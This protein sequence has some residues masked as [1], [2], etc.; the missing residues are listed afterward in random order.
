MYHRRQGGWEAGQMKH[1]AMFRGGSALLGLVVSSAA[2]AAG[3]LPALPAA[4][5]GQTA[6]ATPAVATGSTL[7]ALPAVPSTL[8][9]ASAAG[10]AASAGSTL[11]GLDGFG[12][13]TSIRPIRGPGNISIPIPP[14]FDGHS[15][16]SAERR[17]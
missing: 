16:A 14:V 17:S 12:S 8:P 13:G 7:P 10:G 6:V 1:Q 11:P 2:F 9:T 15:G 3:A 5:A 4:P